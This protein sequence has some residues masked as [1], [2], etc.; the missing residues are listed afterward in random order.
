[1]GCSPA[2]S[3]ACDA[4]PAVRALFC[5]AARCVSVS[6]AL[7]V[8]GLF[9]GPLTSAA[10]YEAVTTQAGLTQQAALVSRLHRR[11]IQRF[12]HPLGLFEPLRLDLDALPAHRARELYGRLIGLDPAEGYAPEWQASSGRVHPLGRQHVLGWLS[13][14]TVIESVPAARLANHFFDPATGAGLHA[15]DRLRASLTAVEFGLS[16]VRQLLAGAA[17]DG[18]GLAAP[19][20][21]A[22]PENVNDLGLAAFL[23][24][25]ERAERAELPGQRESALAEVLLSAGAMLGVLEQMGDPAYLRG[26]LAEVLSG[27]GAMAVAARFGRAGVPPVQP[28]P[29]ASDAQEASAVP[30]HLRD[31]F[32]DGRGGGLAERTASRCASA[33]T[34][35]NGTLSC[36]TTAAPALLAEVGRYGQRLIDYLFRGELSLAVSDGGLRI[37][38][39]TA[40]LPFGSGALTLLGEQA[41]GRRR[42]LRT[43]ATLPTLVGGQVGQFTLSPEERRDL[44]R[45]VVLF[46]GRDR[47]N[48]PIVTSAQSVLPRPS[49]PAEKR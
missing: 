15:P 22:A 45:V 16:S 40:E 2:R 1:M 13:A 14:G 43:V 28:A 26:D 44:H 10:A 29:S 31:L 7:S 48:E 35:K 37:E 3:P 6:L 20:W 36:Y 23:A 39:V 18:N 32:A 38:V 21:V 34:D 47:A 11:M 27:G 4:M 42:V 41:E 8:G 12:V 25:Y 30:L 17:F 46:S 24:A 19:D 49:E 9:A 33:G 5:S